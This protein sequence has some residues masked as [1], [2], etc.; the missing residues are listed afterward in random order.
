MK[1]Y[2]MKQVEEM[3]KGKGSKTFLANGKK[4]LYI[5]IYIF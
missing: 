5:Y 3:I 4:T 1:L 2:E